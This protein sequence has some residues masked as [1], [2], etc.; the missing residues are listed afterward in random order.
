MKYA[1]FKGRLFY[2]LVK[3]EREWTRSLESHVD[4]TDIVV[5]TFDDMDPCWRRFSQGLD[6][7]VDSSDSGGGEGLD[8]NLV[9]ELEEY[10]VFSG[11]GQYH[12]V[13]VFLSCLLV[14]AQKKGGKHF[15]AES[16]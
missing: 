8:A 10:M 16:G 4:K 3:R 14:R 9:K 2:L 5:C 7:L 13:A 6:F 1:I 12:F 15:D 11:T